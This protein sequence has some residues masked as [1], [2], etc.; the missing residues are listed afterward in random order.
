ME[1]QKILL[2]GGT[3]TTEDMIPLAHRNDIQI[4]VTDYYAN[5]YVKSIA[6]AAYEV[7]VTDVDEVAALCKKEHY[8]GVISAYSDFLS[9]YVAKIAEKIGGYVPFDEEQLRLSTDKKFFKLKCQEYGV[10]VPK[11]YRVDIDDKEGMDE[12]EYPVIVKPIDGSGSR[13]ISVCHSWDELKEAYQKACNY[14]KKGDVL[15]EQF[16][17]GD[18][19]NITYIAQDGDIQ[20]AAIHDRYFNMEQDC[21]VKV[22][23]LYI[24]PSRYV[25]LFQEKFNEKVIRMLQGMGI[26]NGSL[27]LQACVKNE[28]IYIYEAGMRL[29]GCKTYQILEVEND[30]NTQERLM[31]Y[32]LSGEMGKKVK[33]NP[34]FKR[35]YA[36][37]NVI[38][39]PGECVKKIQGIEELKSYPW[40]IEI[41]RLYHEGE[42]IPENSMGTLVQVTS[43]IHIYAD[44]KEQLFERINKVNEL[45]KILNDKDENILLKPHDVEEIKQALN[46][47]L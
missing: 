25:Q 5:T 4:G 17:E 7:S 20:V 37:F 43:R 34:N 2:I 1:Q 45:Y 16:I 41:G 42:T 18:E 29:N 11:E 40:L 39:K 32:A 6:D 30:Y 28:N 23:D 35:W 14:S 38:G 24:Y 8:S 13:G 47:E 19:I 26:R 12:I 9:P 31:Y 46:Y 21:S 3:G 36:T 33:F 10:L 22:P 44:T 27:F 15:V